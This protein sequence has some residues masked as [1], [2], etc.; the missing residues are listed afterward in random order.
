MRNTGNWTRWIT[1]G[2]VA[3]A[4]GVTSV[5]IGAAMKSALDDG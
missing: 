2:L 1:T 5:V 4:L 3:I